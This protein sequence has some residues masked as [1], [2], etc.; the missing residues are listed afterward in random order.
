MKIPSLMTGQLAKI[1]V[2]RAAESVPT[3]KSLFLHTLEVPEGIADI[4]KIEVHSMPRKTRPLSAPVSEQMAVR[5]LTGFVAIRAGEL[6][7]L[8]SPR[9]GR[10]CK[11]TKTTRQYT[12][13]PIP[14]QGPRWRIPRVRART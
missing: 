12:E 6:F 11:Y 10:K 8:R 1:N 14:D 7:L 5:T 4:L 13:K 9:V 3:H 2:H